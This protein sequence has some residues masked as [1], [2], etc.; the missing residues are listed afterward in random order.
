[1]RAETLTPCPDVGGQS[2]EW[3]R[4]SHPPLPLSPLPQPHPTPHPPH[5]KDNGHQAGATPEAGTD[6]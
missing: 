6:Y 2:T 3:A 1:M 5:A 4:L